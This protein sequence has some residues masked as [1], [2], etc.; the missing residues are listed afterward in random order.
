MHPT[1]VAKFR[2][3]AAVVFCGLWTVAVCAAEKNASYQAA[4]ESIKADELFQY[5]DRLASEDMEGREAGTKGGLA[6]A[7]YLVEQY[8]RL[9]LNAAG[10]DGKFL[11]PFEPNMRNV[12]A[13]LPGSDPQLRD[14]VIVVCAHF[15]HIGYGGKLS[16]GPYGYIHPG[17]DDNASGTSAVVELAKA[18]T[19]LAGPPK[20][21]ILFANWDGEEKGLL[22]SKHWID[23]PTVPLNRV[24]AAL[25]MD[26]IG[27]LREGHLIVIG[28]RDGYGWRR[29][30][31]VHNDVSGLQ[32]NFLWGIKPNADY[33]PFT[34][35][36]IP[37]LLFHTGLHSE[38]HR[39]G[40]V[41]KLINRS[42]MEQ[43]TRIVFGMIY[44]LA[45]RPGPVPGFRAAA[46]H[47]TPETEQAVLGQKTKPADRLGVGWNEDAAVTDGVRVSMV[48]AGSPAEKA[49]LRVDDCIVK[50]S[51]QDIRSDDD[52]FGVVC[53]AENPA[54]MTVKRPGEE[55]TLVLPVKLPGSPLKW[56]ILW[57]AD[58]AEPGVI[59]LTH[60]VR[61]S[62]AAQAGLG[63]EDRI[64]Q[65]GGRDFADE[66][67]F[68][69][70]AKTL[71]EPVQLLVE[72]DG[73]LRSVLLRPRQVEP[74]KRAA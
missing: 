30:L 4:L 23:H 33:F 56:G 53:T 69:L 11:Q 46:R 58:D 59:I 15:D 62:P 29:L 64:Y 45:D 2:L 54:S 57:R 3:F 36:D 31:S 55:K 19:I 22:G 18:F 10:D 50:F 72:R 34:E 14:Q 68:A 27:R 74:L 43:V 26:M 47:E 48:A 51:G 17:A 71:S 6:A 63:V 35:H 21:S 60:V 73:R 12:L 13:I 66:A 49:G 40:D 70:L 37:A 52:F 38:Y 20:R 1:P 32:L 65:V 24:A 25:N 39:P 9:H 8:K 7:E 5:V 16:L 41:A 42:G 28:T 67:G 61:G 44:D